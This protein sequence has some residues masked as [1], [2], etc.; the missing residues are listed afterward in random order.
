MTKTKEQTPPKPEPK[1]EPPK[2][3]SSDKFGDHG[4]KIKNGVIEIG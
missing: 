4:A 2:G 3:N 1:P